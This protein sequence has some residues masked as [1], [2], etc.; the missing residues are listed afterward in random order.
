M[1]E[2]RGRRVAAIFQSPSMA[3][4]PVFRV[5]S[6]VLRALRLHGLSKQEAAAR[7]EEAL[8]A[9]LL[10][11][12][13]LDRYPSQLSGGQLQRVAIALALALRAE[14]LLADEPTSA[15]DVT[16]QAEVL[17]LLRDLR[18]RQGMSVLFISHDLAVVAELCD[19]VAIMRDGK[20]VEQGPTDQV[21]SAPRHDYTAELLA[22]VP[23]IGAGTDDPL[24]PDAPGSLKPR[25][26]DPRS[27]AQGRA[28]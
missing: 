10:S 22:S 24:I 11:P 16:V 21:V 23:R 12:G 9:V 20:I 26:P 14:V 15:L 2:I 27:A 6:I 19:R 4:S 1:R 13:L 18:E 7:A 17:E 3:F 25:V 5:G 28:D 8:R